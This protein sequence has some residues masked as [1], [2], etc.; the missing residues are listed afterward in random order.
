MTQ[1]FLK[2]EPIQGHGPG[3]YVF[4]IQLENVAQNE[5]HQEC[6]A[7]LCAIADQELLAVDFPNDAQEM[8][9]I[10]TRMGID[11]VTKEPVLSIKIRPESDLQ[12]LRAV[13]RDC[14]YTSQQFAVGSKNQI[15]N[16]FRD[17]DRISEF[18]TLAPKLI[19]IGQL[20]CYKDMMIFVAQLTPEIILE[21]LQRLSFPH[22]VETKEGVGKFA[23]MIGRTK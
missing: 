1:I 18:T 10:L 3:F 6:A 5:P 22:T 4:V 9:S 15:D 23:R 20:E 13:L 12:I 11:F 7:I 17:K 2:H 14:G 16:Y 19:C 8:T 21:R